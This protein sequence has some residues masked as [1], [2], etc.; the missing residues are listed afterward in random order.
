VLQVAELAPQNAGLQVV[1][2]LMFLPVT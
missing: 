2:K 1:N